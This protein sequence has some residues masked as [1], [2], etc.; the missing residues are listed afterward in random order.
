MR[1]KIQACS[2]QI[3]RSE[4]LSQ[5]LTHPIQWTIFQAAH[6][7]APELSN[8]PTQTTSHKLVT[9]TYQQAYP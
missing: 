1:P 4:Y 5:L 6:L 9:P 2:E 3:A 7:T 8:N